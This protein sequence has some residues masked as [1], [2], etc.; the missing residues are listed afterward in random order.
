MKILMITP[1][2]PDE[3]SPNSG[4]FIRTQAQAL[5]RT[6]HEVTVISSRISYTS[7]G[8]LSGK[9]Q[10]STDAG[11]DEYRLIIKKSFPLY[12]QLN[13]LLLTVWHARTIGKAFKPDIVHASIGYPGAFW[14][15][16]IGRLLGVPFVITEHTRITNNFRSKLHRM[17]TLFSLKRAP[18]IVAVSNS[19][20]SEIESYTKRSVVVIPNT[21]DISR[22]KYT[23]PSGSIP[24]IG[25]L[26]GM[27]T[28]V[29]GLDILLNALG[30][31]NPDFML[32]IGGSGN[33]I[34]Q[35]KELASSLGMDGK[36]RFYGFIP[37]EEVPEFMEGIHFMVCSSRYETFCVSLIEAMASGKPVIATRCGG[38]EGFVNVEN[39]ILVDKE[40]PDKLR[41]G[42]LWMMDHY[43]DFDAHD[44][45]RSVDDRFS[46]KAFV[47]KIT[48]LY[49][50]VIDGLPV[51]D[52]KGIKR[53]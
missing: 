1:W 15:W 40:N 53:F 31:I 36:C 17:L 45:K 33:L 14:G 47:E 19:L 30:K 23:A 39:G 43:S 50:Q 13:F 16:A 46:E 5:T 25:F 28:P 24:Q 27:N 49:Q 34:K 6:G 3:K 44:I 7:F 12:N 48:K 42:L 22:F 37:Y 52:L 38:P 2:Y 41:D 20:A 29:K 9:I 35:Y 32:H 8:I 10:K 18:V 4:V 21:I 51:Q 11:V 26:G